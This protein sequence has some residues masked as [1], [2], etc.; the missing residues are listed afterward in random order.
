MIALGF[1]QGGAGVDL[2]F[3]GYPVIYN[4]TQQEIGYYGANKTWHSL[5]N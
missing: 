5:A 4:T 3:E 2:D 1:S